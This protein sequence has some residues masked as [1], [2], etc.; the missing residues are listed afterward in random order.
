MT[1]YE[2]KHFKCEVNS[3]LPSSLDSD[4]DHMGKHID[5]T[6]MEDRKPSPSEIM[7]ESTG[8]VI[9]APRTHAQ[10]MESLG[11]EAPSRPVK[12]PKGIWDCLLESFPCPPE[13]QHMIWANRIKRLFKRDCGMPTDWDCECDKCEAALAHDV[14]AYH[15]AMNEYHEELSSAND[16]IA[17]GLF[18]YGDQRS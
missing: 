18:W 16:R 13:M 9:R 1:R 4:M 17:R 8:K 12:N 5:T 7:A 11:Y 10:I 15:E 14:S 3:Q 6:E 2:V